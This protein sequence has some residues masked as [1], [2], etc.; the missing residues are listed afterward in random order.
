VYSSIS[1]AWARRMMVTASRPDRSQ[2]EWPADVIVLAAASN[3]P[4]MDG[5]RVRRNHQPLSAPPRDLP[6]VV[7][8]VWPMSCGLLGSQ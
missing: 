4:S 8:R 6:W 1:P 7:P 5:A 3:R 2:A